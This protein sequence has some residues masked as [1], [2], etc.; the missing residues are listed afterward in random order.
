MCNAV[1]TRA[2]VAIATSR[3][4]QDSVLTTDRLV[5]VTVRFLRHRAARL[6]GAGIT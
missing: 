4:N 6:S 2:K 5:V 3:E 1:A